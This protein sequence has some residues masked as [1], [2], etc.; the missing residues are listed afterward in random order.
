M[1]KVEG[2]KSSTSSA[3]NCARGERAPQ[4]LIRVDDSVFGFEDTAACFL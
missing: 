2:F 1:V 4:P 3:A